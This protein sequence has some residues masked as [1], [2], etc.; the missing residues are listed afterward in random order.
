[1]KKNFFVFHYLISKSLYDLSLLANDASDLLEKN[2]ERIFMVKTRFFDTKTETK[3]TNGICKFGCEGNK[4]S[5][6]NVS[7]FLGVKTGGREERK[8]AVACWFGNIINRGGI[9]E[10]SFSFVLMLLAL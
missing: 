1:M 4:I 8:L 2:R 3:K 10:I 6:K 7:F 5:K 9:G